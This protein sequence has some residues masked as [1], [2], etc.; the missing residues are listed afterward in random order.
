MTNTDVLLAY[1][2][3]TPG[4]GGGTSDFK[5]RGWSN[6]GKNQNPQKIPMASNKTKPSLDQKLT[7][8]NPMPNFWA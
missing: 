5:W 1:H 2:V 8:K 7:P 3:P 6:G 4:G